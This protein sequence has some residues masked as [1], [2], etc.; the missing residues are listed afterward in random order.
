TNSLDVDHAKISVLSGKIES[1]LRNAASVRIT[2]PNGTDLRFK[3]KNRPVHIHDGI[4]DKTDLDKGTRF[5]TLPAGAIEVAPDEATAEGTVWFDQPTA[6]EG[7]MLTGLQLKFENGHLTD[8]TAQANLDA[9]KGTYEKMSGDKD[10]LANVVI[11][12]NPRAELIGFFTD[13]MVQGTVSIG[14]G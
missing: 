9:F 12:L 10:R 5:E 1:K 4:I 8:Y 3:L 7:K 14:I 13:R 6:L 2:A 11:G